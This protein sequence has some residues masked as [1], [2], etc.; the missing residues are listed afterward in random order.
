M[1]LASTGKKE[2]RPQLGRAVLHSDGYLPVL[3]A[4]RAGAPNASAT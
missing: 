1:F 3:M 2:A 4:F